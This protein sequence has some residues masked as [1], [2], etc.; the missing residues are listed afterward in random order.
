MLKAPESGAPVTA[1]LRVLG[2][3]TRLR[4]LG[5]VEGRELSVG[6][7]G[8]ALGMAQS[9]VSNHL[10][11]LRE[12]RLLEER[13][14]GTS[15]FLR[16]SLAGGDGLAARLWNAALREELAG[17]PERAEDV[18]RLRQVLEERRA[19]SRDFFDRVAGRWDTIGVDF[20]SGQ[21]RQRAVA[22]F[23]PAGLVI[24]D[25]GCGTGYLSRSLLGLCRK[26]V[27]VDRSLGMLEEARRRL[28][29]LPSETEIELRPG[30]LDAL[31]IAEAE[32]DGAVA[33]M[34]LHHLPTPDEALA[35]MR[36]VVKPGGAAVVLELAPHRETW[37][38][39]ELGDLHLGLDPRLVIERMRRAGF[40][41][42]RM[43]AVD[44]G[45]RPNA[46][47]GARELPAAGLPLYLVRGRVPESATSRAS[48]SDP[49]EPPEPRGSGT[50]GTEPIQDHER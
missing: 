35:E 39:D 2:D 42:V 41:A 25:L 36:R 20:A 32:V 3:A 50:N 27:C 16:A 1:L 24:A 6:E 4:I 18:E 22:Q 19:T 44:D 38:H 47:A 45:Y 49:N 46:P 11:I 13:H 29:E 33:A 26:V 12:Q 43:E 7:L 8:R 34:V 5:L 9:R 10:R 17:L 28:C 21:A 40:D 31:P 30:E 15:T 23:V 48:Q 37:M 14:A